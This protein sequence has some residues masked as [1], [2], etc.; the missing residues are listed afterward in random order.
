MGAADHFL[1]PRFQRVSVRR[2]SRIDKQI[3]CLTKKHYPLLETQSSL[4]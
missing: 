4:H 2:H 1:A 3:S